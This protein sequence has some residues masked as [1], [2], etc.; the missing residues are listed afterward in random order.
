VVYT[1]H[2]SEL[3]RFVVAEWRER[4]GRRIRFVQ[5]GTGELLSRLKAEAADSSGPEADLLWGGGA[6]SL[7]ANAELFEPYRSSEDDAIPA[8]YKAADGSWTGFTVLPM[9]IA[10]NARLLGPERAPK[11]WA[12]LFDP[13]L[14]GNIAYADPAAS[15]SAYTILR[16]MEEILGPESAAMMAAEGGTARLAP[17]GAS[18]GSRSS[19]QTGAARVARD[20]ARALGGRLLP[21]S[22]RVLQAVAAGEYLVGV[23]FEN[24]AL[25]LTSKGSD[26]GIVYPAEGTS[27]VPDGVALVRGARNADQARAFIDFVLG[28]DVAAIVS[29]RHGRRS[30]RSEASAP[31]GLPP[32]SELRTIPYDIEAAARSKPSEIENFAR[33]VREA[34]AAAKTGGFGGDADRGD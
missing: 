7:A 24:A 21:E 9:V 19:S 20:F 13:R 10:Y 14:A 15:G 3:V 31:E 18:G 8:A 22:S 30:A 2:P 25:E 23:S 34:E 26:L 1:S 17:D 11:G 28:P 12:D 27:A 32:L 16:T 5:G 4:S 29:S 33:R 6:E